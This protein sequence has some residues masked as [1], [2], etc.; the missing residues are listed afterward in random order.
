VLVAREQRR[1]AAIVAADAV[2]YSRLMGR[3]ESGTLAALKA[4]RREIFDPRIAAHGGRIVKTTR[5]GLLLEFPSVVDAVRCVIEVQAAMAAKVADMPEDRRIA[6]RVG[7]NIGD[8]IIDGDDIFGDGVN[9]AARLQEIA[10][11]GGVAVSGRVHDYVEGR[12]DVSFADYGTQELKNIARPIHVWRWAPDEVAPASV[13]VLPALALPDKPSIAVLP[14]QN[15]SGDPE[16]GYFADSVVED[17]ITAL[18]RFKSLFVIARNSSFTYKGKAVDIKQVERELGVRY[19]LEGSVR[20]AGD[21]LRIAGQLID[22]QTGAHLWVDRFD[23]SLVDIFALQDQVAAGVAG[24][25]SSKLDQAEIARAV[26]K[27]VG[28]LDAYDIFLRAMARMEEANK[29]ALDDALRMFYQAIELDPDFPTPYAMAAR[30][31][32]FRKIQ[33]WIV[34]KEKELAETRRL[35]MKVA[36]IGHDDERALASAGQ[37]LAW[38]CKD[39]D[40]GEALVDQ[41]LAINPNSA[42]CWRMRAYLSLYLGQHQAAIDQISRVFRLN[43][44]DPDIARS[45]GIMA[46]ALVF[47]GRY[48]DSVKWAAKALARRPHWLLCMRISAVGHALG[49]NLVEA[50]RLAAQMHLLDPGMRIANLRGI[51]CVSPTGGRGEADRR[52]APRGAAGMSTCRH[53]GSRFR[54]D[55]PLCRREDPVS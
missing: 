13:S 8:I 1:L 3:D 53:P 9:I 23:G 37:S 46:L 43:P 44:L 20:K 26:R 32:G 36:A 48:E 42:F 14:F 52:H 27:P 45:E 25:V 38:V 16:Q 15:M 33:G 55:I 10:P 2:G 6:F 29:G 7:V 24:V 19:V 51:L 21:K 4:L 50:R 28:N 30:C 12:F 5:D 31:Y 54:R 47:L 22:S 49:G 39:Y 35:A 40:V 34:D 41:A 11:P 17:I 18:S